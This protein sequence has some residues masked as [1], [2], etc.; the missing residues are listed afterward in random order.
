V[1]YDEFRTAFLMALGASKLPT[2]GTPPMEEVLDLRTTDRTLTAGVEPAE[3]DSAEPFHLSGRI[4]FRWDVLETARTVTSESEVVAELL[5]R[6]DA[7]EVDTE[8]PALRIDIKMLATLPWDKGIALPSATKWAAWSRDAIARLKSVEHPEPNAG[9]WDD[10]EASRSIISWQGDPEVRL[11]CRPSG[12]L[13]LESICVSAVQEIRLPR[14]WNDPQR[15]PEAPP[16]EQ[17]KA[18]FERVGLALDAWGKA[19][20]DLV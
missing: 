9:A 11:S 2:L 14:H 17:L 1:T 16:D 18:M 7:Y 5:G 20:T 8:R 12:E 19:I 15:E 4:S 3:R 10:D 13:R 6:E